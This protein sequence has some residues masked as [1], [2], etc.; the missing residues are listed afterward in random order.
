MLGAQGAGKR[1]HPQPWTRGSKPKTRGGNTGQHPQ[2]AGAR[3][4]CLGHS[5]GWGLRPGGPPGCRG[6]GR[7]K[8]PQARSLSR[9]ACAPRPRPPRGTPGRGDTG[10]PGCGAEPLPGSPQQRGPGP[11]LGWGRG[12]RRRRRRRRGT[13]FQSPRPRAAGGAAVLPSRLS[14]EGS[15]APAATFTPSAPSAAAASRQDASSRPSAG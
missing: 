9:A 8:C 13:P 15:P 1:R 6:R 3:S 10:T 14:P 11:G 12:L 4:A 7:A 5:A 2:T